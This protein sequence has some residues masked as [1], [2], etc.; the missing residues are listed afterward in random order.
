ML[1][2]FVARKRQPPG[3]IVPVAIVRRVDVPPLAL[4]PAI[5]QPPMSMASGDRLNSSMN[6]SLAHHHTPRQ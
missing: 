6:S 2:P 3:R 5:F 1:E 4:E